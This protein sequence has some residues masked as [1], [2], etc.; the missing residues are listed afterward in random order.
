MLVTSFIASVGYASPIQS[1]AHNF[2]DLLL[3]FEN[4]LSTMLYYEINPRILGCCILSIPFTLIIFSSLWRIRQYLSHKELILYFSLFV[5][6][7]LGF[8]IVSYHHGYNY[9]IYHSYTK[10][11]V[12]I[13][14]IF[15]ICYKIHTKR[16]LKNN[17]NG[18]ILIVFFIVFPTIHYGKKYCS[19]LFEHRDELFVSQHEIQQ[20]FGPSK[21]SRS[22]QLISSDA[23][24]SVDICLFLCA[25]DQG[26]HMLRTPMRS[27]SLHFA[28]GNLI[29]LPNLN[30]SRPVKVY[31]LVDPLLA[32]DSSFINALIDKFP[33]S[34]RPIQ[35]DSM[36]WSVE[37]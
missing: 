27:L 12:I 1:L 3:Q 34:A 35:L 11:F 8:A 36:T 4:Y 19:V 37:L 22:L 26:D 6:P 5:I 20:G 33:T 14:F 28:K 29:N 18:Y 2:R 16:I 21:F 15:A 7:F 30:S 24:P 17:L 13:F 25:G 10:E 9:L 23:N 31:C 32:Y